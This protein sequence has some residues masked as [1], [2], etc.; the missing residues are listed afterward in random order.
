MN[1]LLAVLAGL[2]ALVLVVLGAL[3]TF[4]TGSGLVVKAYFAAL[5]VAGLVAVWRRRRGA[6]KAE[7]PWP[8]RARR[9]MVSLCLVLAAGLAAT[10]LASAV[11]IR[12]PTQA[13][14]SSWLREH[15]AELER[16]RELVQGSP[17]GAHEAEYRRLLR[18]TG[19]QGA[20]QWA[21]GSV[22]FLY[23]SWGMAN[24]GW[25]ASLVW[26]P[27]E[28]S[29]LLTTIDGFPATKVPGSDHVFS[30]LDGSWY[31]YIVW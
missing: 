13:D 4:V 26:S 30:R 21:N 28:P 11:A 18:S 1:M 24:R 27:E 25:R 22:Y 15:R 29:P 2:A 3:F 17:F 9:A 10:F 19:C 31:A 14:L 20:G 8:V 5:F 16:L 23:R 7:P 6:P 12:P